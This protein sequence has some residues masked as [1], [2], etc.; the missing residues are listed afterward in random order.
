MLTD[1]SATS[2]PPISNEVG[3]SE[4]KVVPFAGAVF[5]SDFTSITS[6]GEDAF[7]SSWMG[8][9]G[10][11][12]HEEDDWEVPPVALAWETSPG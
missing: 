11:F 5:V 3:I 9:C 6:T 8:G 10:G 7:I 1:V 2:N 4:R 12:P